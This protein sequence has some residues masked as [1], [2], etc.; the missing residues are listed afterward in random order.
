MLTIQAERWRENKVLA[1]CWHSFWMGQNSGLSLS[2]KNSNE[3]KP[4]LVDSW[5]GIK[6]ESGP[7]WS[8]SHIRAE[9]AL[10]PI[11][12]KS[13]GGDGAEIELAPEKNLSKAG[14]DAHAG[15]E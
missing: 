6:M 9:P 12:S 3:S 14:A 10:A 1:M 2:F 4:E 11:W 15:D 13:H 7:T 5:L 8:H